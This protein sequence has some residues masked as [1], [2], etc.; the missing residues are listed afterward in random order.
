MSGEPF[1]IPRALFDGMRAHAAAE[2]PREC[3]G[4]LAG[5]HGATHRY[6]LRNALASETEFLSEAADMIAAVKDMRANGTR[7][8]AVYHS[9][10]A[11]A[12]VPSKKDIERNYARDVLSV[13]VGPGGEVRAWRID[14]AE[15]CEM[16]VVRNLGE[17]R[18]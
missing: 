6:P 17:P 12:P 9:H 1:V 14:G 18:A 10:P 3:C 4:L 7:I 11:S 8:L 13:I 16:V 15:V 5:A 2:H